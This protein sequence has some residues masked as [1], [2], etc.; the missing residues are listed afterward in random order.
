MDKEQP[1]AGVSGTEMLDSQW[2]SIR[3][4]AGAAGSPEFV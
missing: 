1:M 3:R 2:H 4:A